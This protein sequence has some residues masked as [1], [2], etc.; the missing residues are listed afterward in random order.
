MNG[1]RLVL[2]A[3][4]LWGTTGS[5]QALGPAAATPLTTGALRLVVGATGLVTVAAVTGSLR[6]LRDVP[7]GTL[8]ITAV[9]IAA[10]QPA[11]F[12]GVERA[13]VAVGTVV[14]IGSAPILAGLLARFVGRERLE[15]R[16]YTATALAIVGTAAVVGAPEGTDLMGI[17]AAL[18]AG[19]AYAIYAFGAKRMIERVGA[20]SAMAAGFGL[21]AIALLPALWNTDLSWVGTVPGLAMVGWLGIATVTASYLLFGAGLATTPLSTT[22]T[23][24]LAE[25]ATATLLGFL[26]LG[27]RP[28]GVA[29]LGV[30]LIL[31]GLALLATT[32]PDS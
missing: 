12:A 8:A 21:A 10:Y 30:G 4:V 18:G 7:L 11:F 23:L 15:P 31:L 9:G 17:L 1:R 3:A 25:P 29:W 14:A 13:G 19:A 20:T 5:A 32:T 22:A 28:G 24:S 26:L 27:E 6:R 2:G 16:W